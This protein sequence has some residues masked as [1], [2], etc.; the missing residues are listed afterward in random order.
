MEHLRT[1][2]DE[3]TV[4]PKAERPVFMLLGILLG[5]LLV[6]LAFFIASFVIDTNDMNEDLNL[7][8]S[9]V[10]GTLED[11]DGDDGVL[12]VEVIDEGIVQSDDVAGDDLSGTTDDTA[13]VAT[14]EVVESSGASV[15]P[16]S[17]KGSWALMSYNT[18]RFDLD[19]EDDDVDEITIDNVCG[20]N[21]GVTTYCKQSDSLRS[22][23]ASEL[24]EKKCSACTVG[25]TCLL[26]NDEEESN[27]DLTVKTATYL[28]E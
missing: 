8:E 24:G 26:W 5:G 21:R 15:R 22:T 13:E 9:V 11:L 4:H 3:Q 2:K 7:S 6:G 23:T 27:G 28:C 18:E 10:E 19:D 14:Q 12:E 20:D 16:S 1:E 25:Q 17:T